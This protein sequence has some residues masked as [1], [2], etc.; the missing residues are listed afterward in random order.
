[1]RLLTKQKELAEFSFEV[2][3]EKLER[4]LSGQQSCKAVIVVQSAPSNLTRKESMRWRGN[5]R[6]H[7]HHHL[8]MMGICMV[9]SHLTR[10]CGLQ[11]MVKTRFTESVEN[12]YQSDLRVHWRLP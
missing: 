12:H 8:H 2:S 10:L 5:T 6:S 9:S 7:S 3:W 11:D 1:M 4:H